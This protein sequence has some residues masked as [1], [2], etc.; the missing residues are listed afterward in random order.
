MKKK[1]KISVTKFGRLRSYIFNSKDLFNICKKMLL[2][3]NEYL[4]YD[5]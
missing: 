3:N 1:N 4:I 5:I 2:K